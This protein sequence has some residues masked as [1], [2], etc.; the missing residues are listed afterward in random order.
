MSSPGLHAV[1]SRARIQRDAQLASAMTLA[2]VIL[3]LAATYRSPW[4]TLL[5]AVPALSG[6][7]LG[8]VVVSAVFGPVHAITLGFGAMLIGEAIDY[9]TYL[10]A[11]NA[12]HESLVDTQSRIG[13]TLL[14]AVA[15]TAC[16]ALAMLLSGFRGLAQ[17]GLLILSGVIVA[18]LVTQYVL[19]R[20]DTGGRAGAKAPPAAGGPVTG[21]ASAAKVCVARGCGDCSGR[22]RRCVRAARRDLGGRS[23]QRRPDALGDE[24]TRP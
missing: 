12:P 24:A 16:G 2:G 22:D 1:A 13:G 3:L 5:S 20:A 21:A 14:L 19:A 17:L 9:P 6:L 7:A 15:T 8:V 4:P 18:G 11:N 23:R 10:F